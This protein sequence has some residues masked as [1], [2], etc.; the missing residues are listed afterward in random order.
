[1]AENRQERKK[2]QQN[3]LSYVS[4]NLSNK[5]GKEKDKG[6]VK[7]NAERIS[8]SNTEQLSAVSGPKQQKPKPTTSA[9]ASTNGGKTPVSISA[10]NKQ[11]A[12]LG[13]AGS[14]KPNTPNL[15]RPTTNPMPKTL[16]RPSI[17]RNNPPKKR[18]NMD[19]NL[20]EEMATSNEN[21]TSSNTSLEQEDS[22]KES[23][24]SSNIVEMENNTNVIDE[25]KSIT[26]STTTRGNDETSEETIQNISPKENL[27]VYNPYEQEMDEDEK[28]E[29]L[30][31]ELAKMGRI[32]AREITKSLSAALIPLQNEINELKT[33]NTEPSNKQEMR[34]L[35]TENDLLKTKVTQLEVLNLKLKTRLS[36]IED[37][38]LENNLLFFGIDEKDTETENDR[39]ETIVGIVASSLPGPNYDTKLQEDRHIQ[40]E[41][42]KRKGKYMQNK[43]RPISVTFTHHR[44]LIDVLSNRKYLP[45]GIRISKEFGEHT[46]SERK[47]LKPILIAANNKVG[48]KRK[49]Q[50][51]GDHL[52]IKGKHYNRE[53]IAELPEELSGYRITSK[54]D[55]QTIRFFGELNPLSNFHHANFIV[56]NKWYH[57]SEQ[58]IQEKKA[59][60]FN[61]RQTALKILAADSALECKHLAR[62]IKN[63]DIT[64]WNEVAEEMSYHGIL[65]KFN[66]NP[67]LNQILQRTEGKTLA[68]SSYD[69]KWGTGIPLYSQDALKSE[70]WIGENLLGKL[71][72][73]IRETL[74][75]PEDI[76]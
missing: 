42:L 43:N 54:E 40:I 19:H 44:D 12:Q 49:C 56:D 31:P 36:N 63:Y 41:Q 27:L 72:T 29:D 58:Y 53:N 26:L 21:I 23:T 8:H 61:D 38:L 48:Y 15:G 50:L 66:Q 25:E 28:L 24:T 33:M 4:H 3:L 35:L 47:F 11:C 32:L 5:I 6:I 64:R 46:E 18:I 75:L 2:S 73:N 7:N 13:S 69:R 16:N 20:G 60:Y 59:V 52:I 74:W 65:E 22:T 1:M 34:D 17:E 62:N 39:Y 68:E 30:G 10:S 45:T 14:S 37:K 51:E 9:S 57:C 71:L 70:L 67:A 76:D 55:T